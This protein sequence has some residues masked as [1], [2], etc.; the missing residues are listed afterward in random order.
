[1][2]MEPG[3]RASHCMDIYDFYK[4]YHSEYA[5]VDGKLSQ[6]AYLSSIDAC[7]RRY[8][9]KYATRNKEA[10]AIDNSHFDFF[11]FHSPY[12]KLVQK[13]FHRIFFCDYLDDPT[14]P[15][16]ASLATFASL[17]EQESYE[18][19]ELEGALKVIDAERFKSAVLPC[20]KV[21]QN[22]GNCYTGSVFGG[23][24]SLLCAE[25]AALVGKRVMVFS[26]GSG[27]AAS[28]Y[29][30]VGRD[31]TSNSSFSLGRIQEVVRVFDR[32][33][34]RK[35]CT[36]EEFSAALELREGMYGKPS[37]K[38]LGSLDNIEIGT[39]YLDGINDKY[40]RK[41]VLK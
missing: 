9:K 36:V 41:Y 22:I 28:V 21:N 25:G 1:M 39:Y 4:P 24:I 3:V 37:I 32:L 15:C 38:P 14:T 33:E 30:L 2:G 29:S 7:Y 5:A 20:C 19:R 35:Q 17:S 34:A 8:K 12:N 23:I 31:T 27:S 18:S 11:C 10:P 26:Y 40:H 6:W 16:M 13:G